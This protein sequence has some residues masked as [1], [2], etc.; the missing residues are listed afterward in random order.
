MKLARIVSIIMLLLEQKKI[1]ATKLAEMFEV[2]PRTIYR[3]I[4]TINAAGIPI[5]T[6]PGVNGGISIMEEYKIEKG[7]FTTSDIISLL[8]GLGSIPVSSEDIINT[9]AKIKGL[10]PKEHIREIELRANQISI[11]YTSWQGS[12]ALPPN[13][14]EIKAALNGNYYLSFQYYDR[15]GEETMRKV[16]PYRLIFKDSNW[17]LQ[18]YCTSRQDFRTFRLSRMSSLQV[19]DETFIP[20]EFDLE[21]PD[22]PVFQKITIKLLVD[23]SLRGWMADF[24]GKEN[25]DPHDN[26]KII[27][28]FPFMESDYG[29]G[30]L[31]RFGDKCECLEPEEIRQEVIRRATNLLKLYD[32]TEISRND[33]VKESSA[34]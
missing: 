5:I 30:Q 26:D 9:I 7:L 4:D 29:Y 3:D 32:K 34:W 15:S 20:R 1:S 19:L 28:H 13:I 8:I 27:V 24:C 6:Y 31:L 23:K 18:A 33:I 14:E 2:T 16:E 25:I 11:D 21:K 22:P 17:Y 12:K 10:V